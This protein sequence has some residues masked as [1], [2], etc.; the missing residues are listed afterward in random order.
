MGKEEGAIRLTLQ[1]RKELQTVAR[2]S[3][4]PSRSGVRATIIL[5]S[6]EGSGAKTIARVLG[7]SLRT[8]RRLRSGWRREGSGALFDGWRPGRPP[9]ADKKY[10]RML[11]QV[12]RTD[13]RKLGYCFAHWTAPRLA[14]YLKL[15][16]GVRLCDEW[17]RRLLKVRGFVWRKTKL[18]IRNLQDPR[19][20]KDGS[21]T[22]LEASEGESTP[23]S[24]FRVVVRGRGALRSSPRHH[25]RLST[26]RAASADRN[27]R[28]EPPGRGLRSLPLS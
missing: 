10:L 5:M 24:D 11:Y 9:L 27:A 28:K 13:P 21:R 7:V 25:L 15:Q 26:S 18:T 12:V 3:D 19:G 1:E 6:A 8:V 22:P 23:G 2:S 16:T 4:Q 14:E 17:V 20:K